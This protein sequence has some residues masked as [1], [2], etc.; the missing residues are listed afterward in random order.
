[1]STISRHLAQLKQ[2]GLLRD[3]REGSKILYKLRTPCVLRFID[4]IDNVIQ[5]DKKGRARR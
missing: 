1:M 2:V 4:C 5:H 3:C